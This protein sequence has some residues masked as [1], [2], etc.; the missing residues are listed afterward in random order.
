MSNTAAIES[1]KETIRMFEGII[2]KDPNDTISIRVL[3]EA[4]TRLTKLQSQA[5]D[6][7]GPQTPITPEA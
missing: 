5:D 1:L 7:S 2:A 4:K 3:K 6:A